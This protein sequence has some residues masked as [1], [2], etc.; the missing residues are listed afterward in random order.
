V[1]TLSGISTCKCH[2][3]WGNQVDSTPRRWW[4]SKLC[5]CIQC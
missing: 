4:G 3:V 1:R 2:I 5:K